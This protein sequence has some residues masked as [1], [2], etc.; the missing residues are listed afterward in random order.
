MKFSWISESQRLP[1]EDQRQV[2]TKSCFKICDCCCFDVKK[3]L[4]YLSWA[5]CLHRK[6]IKQAFV[7][8]DKFVACV[9]FPCSTE[10]EAGG[11]VEPTQRYVM[12]TKSNMARSNC[13]RLSCGSLLLFLFS[14][15][16]WPFSDEHLS[17]FLSLAPFSCLSWISTFVCRVIF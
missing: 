15:V 14:T 6:L 3:L 4:Y 5:E 1:G 16:S 9:G 17:F 10:V 7:C 13:L 2:K 12:N 8:S 11:G